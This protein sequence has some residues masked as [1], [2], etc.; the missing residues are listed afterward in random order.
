MHD[1]TGF[2]WA[3]HSLVQA[4]GR[5]NNPFQCAASSVA[6][7]NPGQDFANTVATIGRAVAHSDA[8]TCSG[9]GGTGVAWDWRLLGTF[10]QLVRCVSD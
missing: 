1:Y 7:R 6:R 3:G 9:G 10:E 8:G 4:W 2:S 5:T